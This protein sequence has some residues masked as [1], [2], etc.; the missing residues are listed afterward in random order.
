MNKLTRVIKALNQCQIED[1]CRECPY[2]EAL[3]Y[4]CT[5]K[6]DKEALELIQTMN[7]A[8]RTLTD[9]MCR[10]RDAAI[11]GGK[12]KRADELQNLLNLMFLLQDSWLECVP[13]IPAK[14]G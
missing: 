3:D 8:W 10:R 14:K 7:Q 2:F 12:K 5:T 13:R 9:T 6:R 1:G 11:L 4:N